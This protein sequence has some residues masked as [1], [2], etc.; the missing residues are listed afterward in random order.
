MIKHIATC[1][2]LLTLSVMAQDKLLIYM[3]INQ[4]DHLKAYGMTF[5]ALQNGA[6]TDWLL[7]YRGG[8]FLLA[9]TDA[10]IALLKGA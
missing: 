10:S 5:H 8:S 1:L 4:T 7:N 9:E 6:K 2:L 3:D